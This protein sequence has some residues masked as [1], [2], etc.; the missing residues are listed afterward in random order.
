MDHL[1]E[2]YFLEPAAAFVRGHRADAPCA[3]DEPVVAW[4]LEQDDLRLH[5]FK[6]KRPSRGSRAWLGRCAAFSP[7]PWS[8]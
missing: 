4:G 5:K 8:T 3:E 7:T 1:A 6:R 2:R